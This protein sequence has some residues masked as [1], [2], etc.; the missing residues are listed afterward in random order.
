MLKYSPETFLIIKNKP[1]IINYSW[2]G[3]DKF[4]NKV[5]RN[6]SKLKCSTDWKPLPFLSLQVVNSM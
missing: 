2:S 1:T 6:K 5:T 3:V 4:T